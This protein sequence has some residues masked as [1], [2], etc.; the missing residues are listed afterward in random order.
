MFVSASHIGFD[1][2]FGARAKNFTIYFTDFAKMFW[3]GAPEKRAEKITY[4]L[5]GLRKNVLARCA[6]KKGGKNHVYTLRISQKCSGS[7]RQKKE[8]K[9]SR[10]Y[11]TDCA[12][13]FWLGAP[14]K[15]AEKITY[16]LH[17]FRKKKSSDPDARKK[18]EK[19]HTYSFS[20]L[21]SYIV[22]IAIELLVVITGFVLLCLPVLPKTG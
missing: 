18:R 15:R 16:I 8:R 22:I 2:V 19:I 1:L 11:F 4:I 13:M 7:V 20:V 5:H 9:K 6:R 3:L 21:Y 17:G 12:K 14:E 10:I